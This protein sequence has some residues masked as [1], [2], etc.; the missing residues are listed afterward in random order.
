QFDEALLEQFIESVGVYPIGS[1]VRLTTGRLALVVDQ[2]VDDYTRPRV[3]A[4]YD[5]ASRGLIKPE[6]LD[7]TL[8]RG[9]VEI[10]CSDDAEDYA[11][12]NFPQIREMVFNSACK[13][14]I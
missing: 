5:I 14:L 10:V 12:P 2:N 7:L 6:D 11:I 3:W 9:R 8:C 4:F 1:V 13:A